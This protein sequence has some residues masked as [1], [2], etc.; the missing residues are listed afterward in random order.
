MRLI[1]A[2]ALVC[3]IHCAFQAEAQESNWTRWTL[4]PHISLGKLLPGSPVDYH[5]IDFFPTYVWTYG[6]SLTDIQY[7]ATSV[8][9]GFRAFPERLPWLALVVGGGITWF[10]HAGSNSIGVV[11]PAAG[12]GKQLAPSEF[13][14]YPFTLGLQVTYPSR[15]ARDFMLFAGAE[16]T[17]NFVSG[18]IPM[19]QSVKGGAALTAG[20]AVKV[21]ELGMRYQT[22]SDLRNL[23]VYLAVRLNPF[24]VEFA[25]RDLA[26]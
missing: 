11:A 22:F 12:V 14:V 10:G 15:G 24:E 18:E 6:N 21:F 2:F 9:F 26:E 1:S 7:S 20:F 25:G 4:Q 23:G 13:T 16:G 5:S 8:G 17:A 3:F 19:D